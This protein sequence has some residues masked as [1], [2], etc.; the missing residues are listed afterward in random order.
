MAGQSTKEFV[1]VYTK[2]AYNRLSNLEKQQHPFAF[3][4]TITQ[5]AT[6]LFYRLEKKLDKLLNYIQNLYQRV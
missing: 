6:G 2:E 5:L 3:A 4:K 1:K